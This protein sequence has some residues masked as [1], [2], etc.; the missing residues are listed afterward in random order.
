MD[1]SKVRFYGLGYFGDLPKAAPGYGKEWRQVM[2][3]E[4]EYRLTEC[5]GLTDAYAKKVVDNWP[6]EL[7]QKGSPYCNESRY[8]WVAVDVPAAASAASAS[9][10]SA[11][12]ASA[13]PMSRR[14]ARKQGSRKQG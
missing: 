6:D 12:A 5:C 3:Y 4:I 1:L 13:P 10:A 11:S 8:Y 7:T 2:R 14:Q 9:A